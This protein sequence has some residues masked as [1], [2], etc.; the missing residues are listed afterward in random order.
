MSGGI[1]IIEVTGT[2]LP[3][4]VLEQLEALLGVRA[5]I[6]VITP[7]IAERLSHR[8][9][10]DSLRSYGIIASSVRIRRT[11]EDIDLSELVLDVRN[12]R[13]MRA[14]QLA[15]LAKSQRHRIADNA[16]LSLRPPRARKFLIRSRGGKM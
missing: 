4:A 5:N 13:K 2:A 8:E 6:Q 10:P 12:E 16:R 9:F 15:T 7:D 11:I 1:L 14:R 3:P